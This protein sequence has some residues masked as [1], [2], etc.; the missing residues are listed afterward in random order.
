[1]SVGVSPFTLKYDRIPN[2]HH[3][4][5]CLLSTLN[6]FRIIC[7][8]PFD[9][10]NSEGESCLLSELERG[11]CESGLCNAIWVSSNFGRDSRSNHFGMGPKCLVPVA[12]VIMKRS[13]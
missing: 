4:D 12:N 10:C 11:L 9:L 5:E 3:Q 7:L 2:I 8:I 13:W 6:N 1:M